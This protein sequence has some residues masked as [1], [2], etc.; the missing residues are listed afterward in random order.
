MKDSYET[1]RIRFAENGTF[2]NFKTDL[3]ST[4]RI[5]HVFVSKAIQVEAYGV[6]TNSYWTPDDDPRSPKRQPM[7]HR[8]SH[9]IR[10]SG[11]IHR[12]IIQCLSG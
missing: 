1:A 10:I 7:H 12:T 4:S 6:L 2:N 11:T 3:Y 8:R 9:S 5:D